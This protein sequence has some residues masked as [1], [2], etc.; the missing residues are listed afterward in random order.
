MKIN[1]ERAFKI[2]GDELDKLSKESGCELGVIYEDTIQT[3]DGW[4]FF[5]NSSE[6]LITGDPMDSLA[7]NGPVF[8]SREGDVKVL[9]SGR[10]WEEQL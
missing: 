6:F 10:D 9:D 3:K 7:G 8:I 1:A 2:L 5:Y 4:I